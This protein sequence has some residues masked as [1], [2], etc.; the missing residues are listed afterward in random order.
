V[1]P[2]VGDVMA[3]TL[4]T[5][6][7]RI[8]DRHGR[9][10]RAAHQDAS[11]TNSIRR[12]TDDSSGSGGDGGSQR[13]EDRGAGS[14]ILMGRPFGIPVYVAPT[15]FIVAALITYA[16]APAV[17][18]ELPGIGPMRY[19]VSFAFAVLLYLSVFVHE[20]SHSV[21]ALRLGLPVRR[22]SLYLL[23]G[24]SEIE[25]EPQTPGR[26]FVVAA[27][28]PL[29]SLLLGGVG[30]LF[31]RVLPG[32]TVVGFLMLELTGANLVVGVFNL[33][34]GLPLDGGRVLR[35]GV[36]KLTG[37][38]LTGTLVAA[39]AGRVLAVGVLALPLL[40]SVATG[41]SPSLYNMLWAA[42]IG[43]FIWFGATQ[44]LQNAKIRERLPALRVRGLTRRAIPVQ[45]DLPLSEALRRAIEA[46]ARG[47]VV[48]DRE[49]KP[50]AL[51]NEAKVMATPEHRRPWVQV[52]EFARSLEPGLVLSAEL[53][54]EQLVRAL[55][56]APATEYLV[57]EPTGEVYGVLATS[58]VERAFA[59]A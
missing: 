39:W 41:G 2:V 14:G 53:A 9:A 24:V 43:S 37:R 3:R 38:P 57:V 32:D 40:V 18:R 35:A 13:P 50:T 44:S 49:D 58:D 54:G 36:W 21:V 15:W 16:F 29:L 6:A 26:E 34:P 30:F 5:P 8:P 28:G 1:R 7:D 17:E 47:L 59:G 10:S 55:Q 51:V 4:R 19:L 12:V 23:G 31:T 48:V 11:G 33:F 27:V 42:I 52:G 22:I 46:G 45:A 25:K 20:L 56:A